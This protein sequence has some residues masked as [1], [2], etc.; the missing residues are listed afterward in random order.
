MAFSK[1]NWGL[2]VG[3]CKDYSVSLEM[4][5]CYF[6]NL[7]MLQV[8]DCALQM[9]IFYCKI[10]RTS[11]HTT[12]V[13]NISCYHPDNGKIKSYSDAKQICRHNSDVKVC[14]HTNKTI[15]VYK[16]IKYTLQHMQPGGNCWASCPPPSSSPW[17]LSS[18]PL[19]SGLPTRCKH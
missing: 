12:K 9:Y 5:I 6:L 13:N 15:K 17:H 14:F 1:M 16:S 2:I 8:N 7:H 11:F 18:S 4:Q 3:I 10:K 19:I